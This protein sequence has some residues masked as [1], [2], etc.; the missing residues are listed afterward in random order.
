M[1]GSDSEEVRLAERLSREF[2]RGELERSKEEL[3]RSPFS[4]GVEEEVY[5][6]AWELGFFSINLPP[7]RGGAEEPQ[8]T[9]CVVLRNMAA[10]D[11]GFATAVFTHAFACQVLREVGWE[12]GA[13]LEES[14][15]GEEPCPLAF[16]VFDRPGEVAGKLV[17]D[18]SGR[19]W[20][21][22]GRVEYLVLGDRGHWAL[23]PARTGTGEVSFFLCPT[24]GEGWSSGPPLVGL[25]L[26]SCPAVEVELEG[27]PA[28]L[29]GAEGMALEAFERAEV[30]LSP[31]AASLCLGIMESSLR[32]AEEYAR[33]RIQGGWEI[34]NWS[35]VRM[36]LSS[37]VVSCRTVEMLVEQAVREIGEGDGTLSSRV[38]LL[39]AQDLV[40]RVTSDGIQLLGGNGYM[41]DYGQE[42]RFRDGH[43]L[44]SLLGHYPLRKLGVLRFSRG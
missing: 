7:E 19:A 32:E 35:E 22:S 34:I 24:G 26:R 40:R 6:R 5:A 8:P 2:A 3:E 43:H 27:V 1:F 31:A 41:K 37:M 21:L 30:L 44:L 25:G 39:V 29:V 38:S 11:A 12:V 13:P 42:K 10:A 36:I 14:L 4:P 16:P 28:E 33:R 15:S 23:L 9:L 18:R 20:K 17:A